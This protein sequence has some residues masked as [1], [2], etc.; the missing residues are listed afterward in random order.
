MPEQ[1]R[2]RDAL[3]LVDRALPPLRRHLGGDHRKVGAAL[4]RRGLCLVELRRPA[5]AIA[6][7]EQA[8]AL[9]EGHVAPGH[10]AVWR[11]WL[12]R[13]LWDSGRDRSRAR[14]LAGQAR[15]D[16]IAAGPGASADVASIDAWLRP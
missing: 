5:S 10:R 2:W 9:P 13:A 1:R 8:V 4:A 15:A 16:L 14:S 7:L 6:P 12:A 3:A 11:F